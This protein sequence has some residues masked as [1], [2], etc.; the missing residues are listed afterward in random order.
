MPP[1]RFNYQQRVGRAGRAGQAFSYALTVCRDRTHDD[2]YFNHPERMTGDIP[3]Q[4]FLD[5]QRPRIVQRVI[6][7]ELLRRAFLAASNPPAWTAGSIHGTF[8]LTDSWEQRKAEVSRWLSRSPEV[9]EVVRR[10][11]A[12]TGRDEETL[13]QIEAWARRDL[14]NEID[15]KI[16]LW[17]ADHSELSELLATAGVLPMFGF[18]TRARNLY[19]ATVRIRDDLDRAI[20]AE[21]PL[22]MAV[23]AFAPGAQVVRDG[24]LHTVVG[25]ADYEIKGRTA[26]AR[27]PL[28][29]AG[30]GRRMRGMQS[31]CGPARRR[32]LPGVPRLFEC[33]RLVPA[34]RLPYLIPAQGL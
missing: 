20:V 15:L 29:P 34:A 12:L 30:P 10:L 24:L 33:V 18:P 5:L 14:V 1:Q 6:A 4:P 26:S 21:R 2:Y 16:A 9:G 11:T 32:R 7:S 8:G 31:D 17:G 25:F 19:A 13:R 28:G 27:D 22:D 3:P 23:S